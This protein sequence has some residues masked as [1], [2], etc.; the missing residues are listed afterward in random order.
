MPLNNKSLISYSLLGFCLAFMGLPLYIYLPNYYADNFNISLQD[1]ALI[2]LATRLIDTIQDPIFGFISD[3]YYQFKRKIIFYLSPFMGLSFLLLFYPLSIVNI[4]LWL[5]IMLIITFSLYSAVYINYQSYAVNFS[6]DYHTKTKIIAYR[7]I[8]F[9]SGIIFAALI[10]AI[11]FKIFDEK[12]SFLIVGSFYCFLATIFAVIFYFFAPNNNFIIKTELNF[13]KIFSNKILQKF[14]LVFLFNAIAAAI[15]AVLIMFFVEK[16]LNAKDLVGIFL[17]LYFCGLMIGTI[18]WTKL[19][20]IIN[21]K[22]KTWIISISLTLI[23][24]VFCYFLGEGDIL[25]YAIIC[26]LSGIAFGG[27]FALSFS[28]LTDIIQK[29][30]LENNQTIIFGFCNFMIKISLT[31]SSSI[32]IY[33]IGFFENDVNLQSEFISFSYAI[34]PIFFRALAGLILYKNF[35]K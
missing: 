21:D 25:Y 13:K 11:L 1:I 33:F 15:P 2:L 14:S 8:A 17:L 24:F 18:L 12:T 32:L 35:I 28:I 4:H 20:K 9:I 6:N 26:I 27:D 7:E 31:L 22:S 3:K 30:K 5:I 34:L 29:D 10:P 19:S 23:I 16:I